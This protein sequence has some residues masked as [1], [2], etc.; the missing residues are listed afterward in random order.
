MLVRL[1]HIQVKFESQGHRSK[2]TVMV[3]VRMHVTT[4]LVL[5]VKVVDAALSEGFSS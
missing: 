5:C 3:R 4:C 1:G 2:F